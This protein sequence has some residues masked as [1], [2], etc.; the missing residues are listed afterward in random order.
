MAKE[1]LTQSEITHYT[2][3]WCRSKGIS[4]S[5]LENHKQIDDV[6]L[7]LHIH[8]EFS[9]DF[10]KSEQATWGQKWGWCYN[11]QLPLKKKYKQ[12][13]ETICLQVLVRRQAKQQARDK[14]KQLRQTV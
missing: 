5:D 11:R 6:M 13:L 3:L 12:A 14:I 9:K 1:S 2:N 8:D 10:T 4:A 7:L